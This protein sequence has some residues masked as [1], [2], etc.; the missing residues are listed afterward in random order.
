M[1]GQAQD[2]VLLGPY[3][4]KVL[5]LVLLGTLVERQG[6]LQAAVLGS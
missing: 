4:L 2:Q 1:A 5:E 3:A 6:D